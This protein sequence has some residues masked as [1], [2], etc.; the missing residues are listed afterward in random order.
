MNGFCCFLLHE[1]YC[2]H[3]AARILLF[4]FCGTNLLWFSVARTYCFPSPSIPASRPASQTAANQH[5][6]CGNQHFGNVLLRINLVLQCVIRLAV[7]VSPE[8]SHVLPRTR[9]VLAEVVQ[10]S[11]T[12]ENE[13]HHLS[14]LRILGFTVK[15]WN[16]FIW[17]S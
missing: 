6:Y 15:T 2:W 14:H 7:L 16:V 1:Y 11:A 9:S 8:S 12:S 17:H 13:L 4:I 3:L 5:P 10:L